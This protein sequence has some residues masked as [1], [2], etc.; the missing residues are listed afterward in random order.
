MHMR[1]VVPIC[2]QTTRKT[3]SEACDIITAAW[4]KGLSCRMVMSPSTSDESYRKDSDANDASV[5]SGRIM[6]KR[7]LS[8]HYPHK[9][10][11]F[12]CI[13]DLLCASEFGESSLVLSK[14]LSRFA[15]LNSS[16]SSASFRP[17]RRVFTAAALSEESN[18]SDDS[19]ACNYAV[20]EEEV[21]LCDALEATSIQDRKS[22]Q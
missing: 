21:A 12:D 3:A 20:M 7:G 5:R 8:R 17:L 14:S 19:I 16:T 15:S 4:R 11:S 1:H 9:A 18:V 22:P 2:G 10:Q 6:K 13:S